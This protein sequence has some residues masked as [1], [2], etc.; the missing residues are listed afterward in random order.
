MRKSFAPVAQ[1]K[2]V[3]KFLSAIT[4]TILIFANLA[5]SSVRAI[6]ARQVTNKA[7]FGSL[8]LSKVQQG[9]LYTYLAPP[10]NCDAK[11]VRLLNPSN[12]SDTL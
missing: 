3:I 11:D 12:A 10:D 1:S 2:L 8:D 9:D 7:K 6:Q 4:L 5:P